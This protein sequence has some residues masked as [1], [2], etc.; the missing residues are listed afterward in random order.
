MVFSIL[1]V[2]VSGQSCAVDDVCHPKVQ[3]KGALMI[4]KGG[5]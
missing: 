1:E 4:W 2:Q 5:H 3:A